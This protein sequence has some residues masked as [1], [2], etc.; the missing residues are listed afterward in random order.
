MCEMYVKSNAKTEYGQCRG[1]GRRIYRITSECLAG[2][3]NKKQRE[4]DNRMR[5]FPRMYGSGA[6]Y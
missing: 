6:F 1:T 2:D 3:C 4:Q 5:H